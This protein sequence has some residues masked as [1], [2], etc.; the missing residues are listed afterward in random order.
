MKSILLNAGKDHGWTSRYAAA[1]AVTRAFSSH[2]QCVQSTPF[3]ETSDSFFGFFP[4]PEI[5]R[6]LGEIGRQH[7]ARAEAMLRQ[8]GIQWDWLE[9]MGLPEQMLIWRSSLADMTI[10]S[11]GAKHENGPGLDELAMAGAIAIHA[12]GPVLAVPPGLSTFNPKGTA[13]VAWNGS[14]EG[15]N[16]LRAALAMLEEASKVLLV[17]VGEEPARSFRFTVTEATDFLARHGIEAEEHPWDRNDRSIADAILEAASVLGAD[18][19]VAG[20]YGHTRIREAVLGGTTRDL[21]R[22]STQ[23]LVLAH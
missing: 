11:S 6:D 3:A 2:L 8:E 17:S 18:Y 19:I 12:R 21:L 1:L 9:V 14:P 22:N 16:A 20:A 7:R 13:L 4:Y 5:A 15:A 10:I 23:P